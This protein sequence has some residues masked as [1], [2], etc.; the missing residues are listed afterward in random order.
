[1]AKIT[2]ASEMPME[3]MPDVPDEEW[4]RAWLEQQNGLG[5]QVASAFGRQITVADNTTSMVK[6]VNLVHAQSVTIANPLSVPIQ[7]IFA[8]GCVG[9]TLGSDGKPNG[10]VYDLSI[11][12]ISAKPSTKNDGSW[13]VSANY[14]I[15][16]NETT[17]AAGEIISISRD[18][19]NGIA[20]TS[21][22]PE[23]IATTTSVTLTPGKWRLAGAVG[24]LPAATTS[25]TT[26]VAGVS[27]SS[28]NLPV[29][30]AG[31]VSAV[32]VDGEIWHQFST[33]AMVPSNNAITLAI[34]AYRTTVAAGTTK[35]L[36]LFGRAVFTVS[37]MTAFGYLEAVREEPYLTG[38]TGRVKLFFFGG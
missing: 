38:R 36:Y 19:N 13:V 24:F 28:S 5:R 21:N 26:L 18:R 16:P 8:I 14:A 10:G 35:V 4:V 2:A 1:M 37:T 3:S 15:G 33:P 17:G 22:D 12:D 6:E 11:P 31:A 32:P 30:G 20:L 25:L 7:G 34:P 9:L 27:S 23:N 29:G